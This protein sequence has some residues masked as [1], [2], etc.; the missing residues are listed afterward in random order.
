ME[1]PEPTVSTGRV[2]AFRILAVLGALTILPFTVPSA[3][4]TWFDRGPQAIHH[5]HYAVGGSAFAL[6]VG[7]PLLLAA[8]RPHEQIAAFD[9][10]LVAT[11]IGVVAGLLSGDLLGGGA[12]IVAVVVVVITAL[13]PARD[14]VLRPP[15]SPSGVLLVFPLLAL[16]P[17]VGYALGQASLQ[18]NGLP[19][20]PHIDMHHYS[21]QVSTALGIVAVSALVALRPPSW[22]VLAWLVGASAVVFGAASIA[23]P[24]FPSAP[25]AGWAWLLVAWGIGFV[26]VAEWVVRRPITLAKPL[27]EGS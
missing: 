23:F 19:G 20:D 17:A 25:A 18:R 11:V 26:S 3:I 7:V 2:L 4:G 22:R 8:W 16:I 5:I 10:V 9:A 21:G 15:L 1:Q 14:R 24:D 6:T 12:L 13:H 27:G